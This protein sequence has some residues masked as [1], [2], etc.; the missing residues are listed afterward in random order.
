M[1]DPDVKSKEAEA[2]A[3]AAYG[4]VWCAVLGRSA[5]VWGVSYYRYRIT[6]PCCFVVLDAAQMGLLLK[7]H[8]L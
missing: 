5:L 3:R 1:A 7:Q 6:G 2:D 4:R 8:V